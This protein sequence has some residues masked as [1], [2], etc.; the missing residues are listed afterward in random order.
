MKRNQK[1]IRE[2]GVGMFIHWGI[3]SVKGRGEWSLIQ[4]RMSLKEY[5][6]AIPG[7]T[8]DEYDPEEWASIAKQ[9]GMEYM[10]LTCKHHD[11]FCLF[12]TETTERNAVQQGPKRD[13]VKSYV[14]ACRKYGLKCGIYF[15]L[16]DWTVPAF[17]NGPVNDPEGWKKFI[18]DIVFRQVRELCSNYGKI[19]I[20][21]YDNITGQS[22]GTNQVMINENFREAISIDKQQLKRLLTAEDYKS[23]E[24][25][26][27]VRSLQPEIL[28]NDRSLLP[29]DFYTAEQN[30][31][32][33]SEQDRVWEACMTMNKHWGYFPSD[34]Y[35]KTVFEILWSMTATASSGGHLLLNVGP[36]RHGKLNP[37]E[38]ERLE[39]IGKWMKINSESLKGCSKTTISGGNYGCASRRGNI[40]YLYIHYPEEDGSV[41]IPDCNERFISAK[42][43]G[44]DKELEIGYKNNNVIIKGG[45]SFEYNSLP[46]I[47]LE[48][49]EKPYEH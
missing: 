3:Y 34:P 29:E 37:Y 4:K 27:M 19:D 39:A 16:P 12:D 10:V 1:W 41:T 17:F 26:A 6:E 8:A 14:K 20:L 5:D 15:S 7:F 2:A 32:A 46:V 33:P 40:V 31:K 18:D 45:P 23:A 30:L 38:I 48:T 47:K 36:D 13:L 24:L 44:C 11:G 28:I 21:W 49:A 9:T 42:V 25:N 35:Y 43:L 22:N